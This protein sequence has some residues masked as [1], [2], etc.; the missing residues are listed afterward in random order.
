MKCRKLF[1][2]IDALN[3]TYIGVWED[4]CNIESPTSYKQG[5]D[6]VGEYLI[7]MALRRGWQVEVLPLETAGNAMCI[8]M[9]P[10]ADAPAVVF[11]GHIDTVHPVGLFG[12]PP[13]HRDETTIRGPGVTDCKGGVVASF[14]A[15][16]ALDR[17][18]FCS[19]P[20]RL[21]VQSDEETGSK[22]SG[23][24]TVEFMCEKARGAIAFFNTE[25]ISDN[26]AILAR[27]GILRYRFTVHGKA[28]HSALCT[29]GASAIAEAAHKILKLE[30][31]KDPDGLTCNCG[32][33]QGGTA[34]NSVAAECSFL[35]DIRFC[36]AAAR[37]KGEKIVRTV[38]EVS[39]IE[40]CTCILEQVS[41]RPA[42][43]L[44][45]RNTQL[46]EKMNDI[47][48][49][50]GLVRLVQGTGLGGSDAAY[51]TAAGIPCVDD[52]GVDG[53]RIHSVEE[54]AL[55]DSLGTAAKRLAAAAYCL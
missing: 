8:T 23:K 18:G 15:M 9:N 40:G 21:I 26:T 53:G 37:E 17:C 14:L 50:N 11:S 33:I 20:V 16:D 47:F 48:T 13:V 41:D 46:L 54:Y 32:M 4:I 28:T 45:Q 43:M 51:I 10:D 44:T 3:D 36:D 19:R 1:D 7:N 5:V 2:Q 35:A 38:A 24:K 39:E 42:M 29:E 25:G 27:K 49:E 34:P 52:L 55:L 30:M 12:Q 22:T 31:M 6:A